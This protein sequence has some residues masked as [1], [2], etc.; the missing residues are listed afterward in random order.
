M[1]ADLREAAHALWGVDVVAD[2]E[3]AITREGEIRGTPKL[4]ALSAVVGSNS[5]LKDF[6]GSFGDRREIWGTE[7]AQQYIAELRRRDK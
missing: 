4:L 7:G 6:Q 2:V 5:V 1:A 3:T